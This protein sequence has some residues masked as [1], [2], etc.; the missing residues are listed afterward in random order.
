MLLELTQGEFTESE[1]KIY[2]S[3]AGITESLAGVYWTIDVPV[4]E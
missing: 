2:W 4:I 1:A 3:A